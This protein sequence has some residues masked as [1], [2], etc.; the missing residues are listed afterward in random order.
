ML[1]EDKA[2]PENSPANNQDKKHF[3]IKLIPPRPT[4]HMDMVEKEKDIMKQHA[5][6]WN[7][8]LDKG[9]V[10]VFGP[11]L[12]PKGVYGLGIV[13]TEDEAQ[14]RILFAEDP[15]VKSGLVLMEIS[16]IHATLRK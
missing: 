15:A 5:I 3:V 2:M 14:A 12:D 10:I 6:Y 11:V 4:F 13:E 8:F 7:S 16:L 1:E 9:I